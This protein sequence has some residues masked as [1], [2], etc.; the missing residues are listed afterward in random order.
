MNGGRILVYAKHTQT[1]SKQI[2]LLNHMGWTVESAADLRQL[3]GLAA[4]PARPDVVMLSWDLSTPEMDVAGWYRRISGELALPCLVFSEATSAKVHA[5]MLKSRIKDIVLPPINAQGIVRRI[6]LLMRT[7]ANDRLNLIRTRSPDLKKT[8]LPRQIL[9]PAELAREK[10]S[11]VAQSG[12]RIASAITQARGRELALAD[13]FE[14]V[15]PTSRILALSFR[16]RG[17]PAF[18]FFGAERN[19]APDR[20]QAF[21][22]TLIRGEVNPVDELTMNLPFADFKAWSQAHATKIVA[23][24]V[25]GKELLFAIVAETALPTL[26]MSE[27]DPW[28]ETD[29]KGRLRLN[30]RLPC[31][32]FIFLPAN[33]RYIRYLRRDELLSEDVLVRWERVKQQFCYVSKEDASELVQYCIR[34][35]LHKKK[36]A[37]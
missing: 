6:E 25:E 11:F 22:R 10:E 32:I 31:D 7:R 20:V 4:G 26:V 27:N 21:A 3:A 16:F 2:P 9:T 33:E 30:T 18:V 36:A 24:T 17:Q 8:R 13:A 28:A 15:S 35:E 37:S 29:L 1:L 14:P 23:E 19:V 12:D 5:D 34:G